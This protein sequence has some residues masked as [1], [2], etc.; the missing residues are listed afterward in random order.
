VDN[1]PPAMSWLAPQ[2]GDTVS[3]T[4][5]LRLDGGDATSVD[6][7][8]DGT[9][10]AHL[11]GSPFS[12]TLDTTTLADGQ[13]T[14]SASA[15]DAAGNTATQSITVTVDNGAPALSWLAPQDGDTV[16]GTVTLR[17]DGDDA[18]SVDV[19]V[20]GTPL[21][22]LT[23]A[24]FTTPLDTT[25]LADGQHTLTATAQDAAGN[26]STQSIS[27]TVDNTPPSLVW[28]LPHDGDTIS[29][30]AT[31]GLDSDADSVDLSLDGTQ[32]AH[33]TGPPFSTTLD[34]TT[35][36]DGPH[37][38]TATAQDAA[39]NTSTQAITVTV[40]NTPPSLSWSAP[41]DGDLVSGTVTLSLDS[42][43]DSVDLSLDGAQLAH[44]T[45]PP[46]STTL[47]T[48]TLPDGPHTL[49]ATAQD[50]AGNTST[51]SITVTVD[52]TPPSLS[53]S[54]PHDGDV[55]SGT[56]TLS[57]DSD[58]DSVDLSLDGTQLAHLTG[59]PFSTTLDTTTLADGPHTLTATAHDAAG[60]TST[61]SITV[62]VDNTP[63]ALVWLAPRDGA[64]VTGSVLLGL[65][66]GDATSVDIAVD[67]APLAQLGEP[68]FSTMFDT[69]TL[70]DGLH[71]LTATA[72]DAAG[73]TAAASIII[74]I[75]N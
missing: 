18:T 64:T 24:P 70:P 26:T 51:H 35:L 32:L 68:P 6:V 61:H 9:A 54:S 2:D 14:L 11:T 15:Q 59:P 40:D 7:S 33:L 67:Q 5:T 71:T 63:P 41:H 19:S 47:D 29:G 10:L 44:L 30:T 28:A 13:H 56:T 45:G 52:N 37:T 60:N 69:T 50:A 57:L 74:D 21:A 31:L 58:A 12:T 66:A 3:G 34:T 42:D 46:F 8:V 1:T 36:P 65:D 62:T 53:W 17:L 25:T 39:G 4:V 49:T 23:T 55:V 48:T 27:V 22:H 20:D 75:E 38:L 73:N 72:R 16:R 43:A